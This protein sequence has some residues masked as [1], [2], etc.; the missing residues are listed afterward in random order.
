MKPAGI[1]EVCGSGAGRLA[2]AGGCGAGPTSQACNRPSDHDQAAAQLLEAICT[3]MRGTGK[4][5]RLS[6]SAIM[7][8]VSK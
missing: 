7:R 1:P 2:W 6:T 4:L 3:G 5:L 8:L